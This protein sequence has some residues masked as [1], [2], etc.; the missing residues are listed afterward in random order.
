[1]LDKVLP[2]GYTLIGVKDKPEKQG[3]ETMVWEIVKKTFADCKFEIEKDPSVSFWLKKALRSSLERDPVDALNDAEL[4]TQLLKRN[5]D[6]IQNRN[7]K[8]GR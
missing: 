4:L 3:D 8:Y 7:D 2:M 1:M 5:L 6:E